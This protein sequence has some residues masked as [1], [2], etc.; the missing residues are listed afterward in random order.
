MARRRVLSE[1]IRFVIL[2]ALFS[3]LLAC[4]GSPGSPPAATTQSDEL[5]ALKQQVAVQA[6]RIT[7]LET[8]AALPQVAAGQGTR[9][10]ILETKV[11]APQRA[12][13]QATP[14]TGGATVTPR[15]TQPTPTVIPAIAGLATEGNTKGSA[16]AKVTITEYTDYL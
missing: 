8:R 7:V 3:G 5:A 4:S 14:T 11:A 15:P 6:T 2:I 13:A 12:A 1:R 9:I 16:T 10:A